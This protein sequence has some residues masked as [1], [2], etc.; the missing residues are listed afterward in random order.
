MK[1]AIRLLAIGEVVVFLL[2][3]VSRTKDTKSK[4]VTTNTQGGNIRC[5]NPALCILKYTVATIVGVGVG[6]LVAL[7]FLDVVGRLWPEADGEH[8]TE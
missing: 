5:S 3:I 7:Q 8:V 2:A 4:D 6:V 1:R